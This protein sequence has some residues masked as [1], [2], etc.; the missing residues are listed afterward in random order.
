MNYSS[1]IGAAGVKQKGRGLA[2]P[3]QTRAR[4][5]QRVVSKVEVDTGTPAAQEKRQSTCLQKLS[6]S[7]ATNNPDP[8]S[9]IHFHN[10]C[11]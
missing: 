1:N 10:D 5:K 4:G 2:M 7:R 6:L 11:F 3:P 9:G 8:K